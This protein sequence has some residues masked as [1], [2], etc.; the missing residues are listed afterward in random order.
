MKAMITIMLALGIVGVAA[1]YDLGNQAPV[2]PVVT[3]PEN[4]PNPER[5]GGDTIAL[6]HVIPSL[7]YS[8]SGTTAGYNNDYDAVCPY[9][10]STAPD[11]VYKYVAPVTE[12]RAIDLCGST[13]DTKL[14]VMDA[15][16][17]VLAC[18][19]DFYSGA[20]CGVYVSLIENFTF[21]AGSTYYIVVDG[22]GAASGTY[23]LAL[24]GPLPPCNL[25][26][27]TGGWP[28]GEP[29]LADEY[30]DNWNGGC[31]SPGEYFEQIWGDYPNGTKTLC[32]VSGWYL[33]N[34]SNYRDTDWYLLGMG[35]GGQ[36]DVTVDA[37]YAT[38][39]FELSGTCAGV[40]TI[41]QQ[42][43]GGPCLETHMTITG[44]NELQAVWF[45]VGPTVYVPP[46]G[47]P[48]QSYDYVCWFDGL[49][50]WWIPTGVGDD[51]ATH[52]NATWSTVKALYQ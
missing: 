44:Y 16:Q 29:P 27:P 15:A 2:K 43:I 45:W 28:E 11:V 6:A 18:N 51:N 52:V 5:Q 34:G 17:T 25:V 19:D 48:P 38:Y 7:P 9:T 39:I 14:Y 33:Y 30:V 31:Y 12:T 21:V 24:P 4:I 1:A 3:Y 47:S 40:V 20:P 32:G 41:V 36:I 22:Y 26:C 49:F 50:A 46:Y 37:E 10:G 23:F 35:S 13:F 8:D 42:A